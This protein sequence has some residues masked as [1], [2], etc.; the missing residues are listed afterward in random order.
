[1]ILMKT[2]STIKC[3][4]IIN[5]HHQIRV[6]VYIPTDWKMECLPVLLKFARVLWNAYMFGIPTVLS[7]FPWLHSISLFRTGSSAFH[8]GQK[9]FYL[10][11][12]LLV[13]NMKHSSQNFVKRHSISQSVG[14]GVSICL[15]LRSLYIIY[16]IIVLIDMFVC[17]THVQPAPFV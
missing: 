16:T 2:R 12:P 7:K 1:M 15:L 9:A 11:G 6:C 8:L 13:Q 3:T 5:H 10:W 17:T 14:I 4:F